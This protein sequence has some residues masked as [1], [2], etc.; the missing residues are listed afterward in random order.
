MVIEINDPKDVSLTY[1]REQL[2]SV[3]EDLRKATLVLDDLQR[4]KSELLKA[5]TEYRE[6]RKNI[7]S[8]HRTFCLPAGPITLSIPDKKEKVKLSI[9]VD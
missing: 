1:W 3:N 9:L 2:K 7:R 6:I 5:M 8:T 4:K